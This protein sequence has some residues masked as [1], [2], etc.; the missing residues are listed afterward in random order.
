MRISKAQRVDPQHKRRTFDIQQGNRTLCGFRKINEVGILCVICCG[1][2]V[3]LNQ[4]C[5]DNYKQVVE[6]IFKYI[7]ILK[8]SFPLPGYHFDEMKRISEIKFQY[9]EKVQAHTYAIHLSAQA[10][11]PF[12]TQWVLN[13]KS[14]YRDWDSESVKAILDCF[15]PERARAIIQAKDHPEDI[16]GKDPGWETERW[17]GTQYCIQKFAAAFL[18]KVCHSV[19][20]PCIIPNSSQS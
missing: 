1:L 15:V 14:V 16:V 3:R 19:I 12:P 20:H 18:T 7:L 10:A 2:G 17:Y 5:T 6:A 13:A 11:A 9:Q 4:L 8:S